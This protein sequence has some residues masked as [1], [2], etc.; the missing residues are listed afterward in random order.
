MTVIQSTGYLGVFLFMAAESALIPIPSEIIMPFSG[1]LV[2]QGKFSFWLVVTTGA[3]GNLV[4]S[5]AAYW[6]GYWGQD[7][8]VRK[9]IQKWGKWLLISLDDYEMATKW[10]QRFGSPIVLVSRVLP[11]VR[12]FIS[13]P[14][15]IIRFP[16]LRFCIL[17]FVGSFLWST[18]L[19]LIG[20]KLR[21][22][23]HLIGPYFRQFD[24]VIV[25]GFII[26][27]AVYIYR[28]LR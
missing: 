18:I 24:I 5:L 23:W 6:L 22:N 3:L 2:Y 19:T 9:L 4:G 14:A 21:E 1:L 27:A 15:G 20:L 13:L 8:L 26:L 17:T 12:T 7:H 28:K 11:V 16:L 25:V 10:F